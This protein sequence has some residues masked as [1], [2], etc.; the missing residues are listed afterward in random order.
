MELEAQALAEEHDWLA[1][2][3]RHRRWRH[4]CE[5]VKTGN[6]ARGTQIAMV[7]AMCLV[8]TGLAPVERG[9]L[10][11]SVTKLRRWR[12]RFVSETMHAAATGGATTLTHQVE[13]CLNFFLGPINHLTLVN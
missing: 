12:H 13:V 8:A 3:N 7:A 2:G 1:K 10:Q 5:I 11:L 9:D 4:K 6:D